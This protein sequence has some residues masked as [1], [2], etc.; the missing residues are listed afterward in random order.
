MIYQRTQKLIY[1]YV[2]QAIAKT[3][4]VV[5]GAPVGRSNELVVHLPCR[6][7]SGVEQSFGLLVSVIG[8]ASR[9]LWLWQHS[10]CEC[11]G[12]ETLVRDRHD[13]SVLL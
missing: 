10:K 11:P 4:C 6:K 9:V 5:G 7:L 1:H 12:T 3:V 13:A 8:M 2:N